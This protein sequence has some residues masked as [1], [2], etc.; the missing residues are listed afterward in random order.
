MSSRRVIYDRSRSIIGWTIVE[1]PNS[2]A[3]YDRSNSLVGRYDTNRDRTYD[4]SGSL[5]GD[6]DH[7]AALIHEANDD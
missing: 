5:V 4:R 3:G 7:L 1:G 2:I 6:G